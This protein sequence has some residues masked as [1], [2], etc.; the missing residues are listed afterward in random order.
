MA[1]PVLEE[2]FGSHKYHREIEVDLLRS[3]L[4]DRLIQLRNLEVLGSTDADECYDIVF[5]LVASWDDQSLEIPLPTISML[6]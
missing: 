5:K 1:G 2:A 4:W 6:L 3:L